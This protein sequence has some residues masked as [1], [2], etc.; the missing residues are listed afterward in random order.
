MA[1]DY[2]K[3]AIEHDPEEAEYKAD[4]AV[5]YYRTYKYDQAIKYYEEVKKKKPEMVS[6]LDF[7]ESRGETTPKYLKFD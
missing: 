7:I 4:L 1:I 5:A 3:K 2:F 6:Q